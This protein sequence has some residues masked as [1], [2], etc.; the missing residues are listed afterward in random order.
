MFANNL[1]FPIGKVRFD[2]IQNLLFAFLK[3]I[4]NKRI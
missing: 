4:A 2:V 1:A 3:Q